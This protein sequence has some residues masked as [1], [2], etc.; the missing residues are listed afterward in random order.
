MGQMMHGDD[1]FAPAGL[2]EGPVFT[3]S[4]PDQSPLRRRLIRVVERISGQSRIERLYRDWRADPAK[5]RS[6]PVFAEAMRVLGL[7]I[8]YTAGDEGMIP[9]TG[10]LLVIANHPFGIA[11]G[12]AIGDLLT[13][14]RP[15]VKLMVNAALCQAPEAKDVLL[16][17]DFS[18]GPEARRTSAETRRAATEWLEAGHVLVIFPAGGVATAPKP[19]SRRAADPAWHPFVARLATRPGVRVLP[20]WFH[21]QNSRLFQ[22][23]SH[24]SYPLRVALIFRETLKRAKKPLRIAIGSPVALDPGL[25]SAATGELRRLTYELAGAKGPKPGV[26]FTFPARIRW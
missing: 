6:A 12:L 13:R 3:Y 24:Y 18:H 25:K 26:E 11:D 7:R 4:H 10:G 5:D 16:P 8:E 1:S 14:V 9:K 17:V 21:G 22:I 2:P 15:D 19:L 23:A 20:I